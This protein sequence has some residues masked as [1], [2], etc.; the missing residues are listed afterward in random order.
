LGD[1]TYTPR[2][3]PAQVPG[4]EDVDDVV[5]NGYCTYAR[6]DDGTL[7]GWGDNYS[8]QLGDGTFESHTSPV[9]VH[10]IA[11]VTAIGVGAS[12]HALAAAGCSLTCTTS[13]PTQAWEDQTVGL[14]AIPSA[15]GCSGS[16]TYDWDFGDGTAHSSLQS[17]GHV[18][19][20]R[21]TYEWSVTVHYGPALLTK[22][23][24]I[25]IC[26]PICSAT[27]S[28]V[29]GPAPLTVGFANATPLDDGC[30]GP[31][32]YDWDFGDGSAHSSGAAPTH[33]YTTNGTFT[34][35]LTLTAGGSV[36][37]QSG[38][39]SVC[40]VTCSASASLSSGLIPLTI[41]FTGSGTASEGCTGSVEYDWDFGDGSAHST[42]QSPAHTYSAIGSYTWMLTVSAGGQTCTESGTITAC[43]LDYSASA[44]TTAGAVPLAVGFMASATL[45]GGCPPS[46]S[47]DW[48]FGDGSP[49]SSA[50]NPSHTYG[51]PGRYGWIVRIT[52]AGQNRVKMGVVRACV[53][54]CG[55]AQQAYAWGSDSSGQ[56]G[57]SAVLQYLTPTQV[58][59]LEG[60]LRVSAGSY[61]SVGLKSDGTI[62]AWGQN[63]YGQLGRGNYNPSTS[64]VR[65][66]NVTDA[67]SVA[68]GRYHVLAVKSDGT[69]WAW[70]Y[71]YHGQVGDG[72]NDGGPTPVK[73][74]AAIRVMPWPRTVTCGHGATT[75]TENLETGPRPIETLPCR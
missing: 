16:A 22:R 45:S 6:K 43:T 47:Y 32:T 13:V 68:C 75:I 65:V 20:V 46:V 61:F 10:G 62:W 74:Q 27:A 18:Y 50:Q 71:G 1:G 3:I 64:P 54:A 44:S 24:T 40:T 53:T 66:L 70:G 59:E 31:V 55:D 58:P 21:G 34:W 8:G 26:G 12:Y 60:F 52:A 37:T 57:T 9:Q 72:T 33:T 41:A 4:L 15:T 7:W 19:S 35:V 25:Q 17:P 73:R 39:I 38:T 48:D 5:A 30:P 28:P 67:V 2:P 14:S 49:H 51:S 69:V 29:G 63:S 36:C 42:E 11:D 23:G 56:L